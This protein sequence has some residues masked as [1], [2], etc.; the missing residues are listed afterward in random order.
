VN[1]LDYLTDQQLNDLIEKTEKEDVV[2]S[3]P[4]VEQRVM[5]A[6]SKMQTKENLHLY[7]FKVAVAMVACIA[8]LFVPKGSLFTHRGNYSM[9]EIID[10]NNKS[11]FDGKLDFVTKI[12]DKIGDINYEKN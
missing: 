5:L 10:T 8:I 3:P 9:T 11:F 12:F 4:E 6:I 2:K 7:Y 1:K